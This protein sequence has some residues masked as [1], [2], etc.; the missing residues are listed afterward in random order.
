ME[1]VKDS[2]QQRLDKIKYNYLLFFH[3][4]KI[5]IP[6]NISEE[7]KNK[8]IKRVYQDKANLHVKLGAKKFQNFVK[9]FDKAKFKFIKRVIKEERLL[10]WHDKITKYDEDKRLKKAKTKEEKIEILNNMERSK[11]L[12][13]KQLKE[14]RSINYFQGVDRRVQHFYEYIIRNKEIHKNDLIMNGVL[15][16]GS[17]GLGM[18]GIPV[19]PFILGGYQLFAGFK[20]FQCINAQNYYLSVMNMRKRAIVKKNLTAIKRTYEENPDLIAEIKKGLESGKNLYNEK[21]LL[22]SINTIEGLQ[23]LKTLLIE[24]RRNQ[25]SI[26]NQ[27]SNKEEILDKLITP[28]ENQNTNNSAIAVRNRGK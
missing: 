11:V 16:V 10:K 20:N 2:I 1:S 5:K 9:K 12:L 14:E 26:M 24:A 21:T 8:Y 27:K 15:L 13:R 18:V 6:T 7:E 25:Q 3:P 17:V 19:L 28:P 4:E 23:Q 22:D